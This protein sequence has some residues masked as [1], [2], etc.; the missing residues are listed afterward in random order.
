MI[1]YA[2]LILAAAAAA[3]YARERRSRRNV[4]RFGAATLETL[5]DSI[6]ANSPVTG[7]HVRRVAR[8]AL[9]IADSADLDDVQC[10]DTERVALFHDIGKL[11]SALTDIISAP[12]KLSP[13]EWD[14]VRTHPRRGADVLKPLDPF[15]PDLSDGVLSHH[16]RWD[17]TGYPRGLRGRKIPLSARIVAIA[18]TFDAITHARAY[19]NP[20]SLDYAIELIAKGRGTQFD[21]ELVDLFLSPPVLEQIEKAMRSAHSPRRSGQKKRNPSKRQRAPDINFRWR[22]QSPVPP[23]PDR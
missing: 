14:A 19:S 4:T 6:E 3:L 8:Y 21:P 18:D 23:E 2:S 16:E 15:Y 11:D 20:K 10:H 13:G 22:K 17:G 7:A 1:R 9:I 12:N 5:L